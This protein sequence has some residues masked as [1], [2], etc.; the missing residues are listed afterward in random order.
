MT[1]ACFHVPISVSAAAVALTEREK[2][3][4]IGTDGNKVGPGKA[5]SYCQ[6]VDGEATEEKISIFP[7]LTLALL[8]QKVSLRGGKSKKSISWGCEPACSMCIWVKWKEFI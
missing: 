2:W 6:H 5:V 1:N 4:G 3:K 8:L 7:F